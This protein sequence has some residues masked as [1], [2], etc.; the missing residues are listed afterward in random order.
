MPRPFST[1]DHSLGMSRRELLQVGYC[2]LL[3]M[4]LPSLLS[5]R[6]QAAA[7]AATP[8]GRKA[9]SVIL[10]FLTGAPSHIDTFDM[11]PDAPAEVRGSFQP[12]ATNVPGIQ[13]CEHLPQLAARA[14]RFAIVRSMTHGLPS[15]EHATHMLLTGIDKMPPGSTHMASRFDW[16]C[17]ASG[18]DF[19]SRRSDGVP[20]GVMLPTYLNNGYGFSGQDAGWL[21]PKH[22]PWQI[23]Q[24][25]NDPKFK[26][27]LT[28]LPVG[29][30]VERLALRKALLAEIEQQRGGLAALAERGPFTNSKHFRC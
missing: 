14:D 13:I 26:V 27:E 18:L 9:K 21:G 24:D 25:P 2:G 12:I 1:H 8:T 23:T 4:G 10:I 7:T 29:L 19:V 5:R 3:G 20:N 15:H 28:S 6:A 16:P 17:Y 30:S 11:K 22:D